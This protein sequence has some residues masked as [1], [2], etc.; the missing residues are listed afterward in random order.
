MVVGIFAAVQGH[1]WGA[2]AALG[3]IAVEFLVFLVAAVVIYRR[4]M[5][6]PWPKVAPVEDED[7][8]W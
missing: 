3:A 1:R 4:T 6:R 7:D 2:F 5:R 8:D